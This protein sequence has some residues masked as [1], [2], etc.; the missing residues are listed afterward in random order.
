MA[1]PN[2]LPASPPTLA[3]VCFDRGLGEGERGA[4]R[5]TGPPTV[6]ASSNLEMARKQLRAGSL[7]AAASIS[8]EEQSHL[9]GQLRREQARLRPVLRRHGCVVLSNCRPVGLFPFRLN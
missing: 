7:T 4:S 6:Q 1:L 5:L 3:G 2:P 9:A 8:W